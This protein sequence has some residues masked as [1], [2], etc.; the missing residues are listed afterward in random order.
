MSIHQIGQLL[1]HFAARVR[2]T[3]GEFRILVYLAW[4]ADQAGGNIYEGVDSLAQSTGLTS[5]YIK[6]ALQRF[7]RRRWM[8]AT[9]R[10][11]RTVYR[12]TL[13]VDN[14]LET[15]ENDDR[16]IATTDDARS[17]DRGFAIA[18]SLFDDPTIAGSTDPHDGSD[19][20]SGICVDADPSFDPSFD[21]S[22]ST[23]NT[24]APAP[25]R[26]LSLE[27][28]DE[29]TTKVESTDL[30]SAAVPPREGAA[31]NAPAPPRGLGGVEGADQGPSG[32]ARLPGSADRRRVPGDGCGRSR[33]PEAPAAIASQPAGADV[34]SAGAAIAGVGRGAQ[35][36]THERGVHGDRR[37]G[38]EVPPATVEDARRLA[39][40]RLEA[41]KARLSTAA[42]PPKPKSAKA[43]LQEAPI[44]ERS[45]S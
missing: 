19:A 28:A 17:Q 39:L 34:A 43:K 9:T 35:P 32:V 16:A 3:D 27:N 24:G 5:P 38:G 23:K 14:L 45:G 42:L 22:I 10:A 8:Q 26:S 41:L 30:V 2:V 12:L 40:E 13:P 1:F 11:G 33:G 4:R 31:P 6:L 21:P 20:S 29:T 44:H 15:T 25:A 18:G 7:L 37:P 36:A